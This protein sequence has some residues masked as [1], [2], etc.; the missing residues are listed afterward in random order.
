M[1]AQ[2]FVFLLVVLTAE[3]QSTI[4]S[5]YAL[6]LLPPLRSVGFGTLNPDQG[7]ELSARCRQHNHQD[8]DRATTLW[9]NCTIISHAHTHP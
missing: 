7:I 9:H 6:S 8:A 4:I 1:S 2:W 5:P 3:V